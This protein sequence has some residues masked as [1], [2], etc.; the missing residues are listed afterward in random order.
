MKEVFCQRCNKEIKKGQKAARMHMYN[1]FPKVSD[2][3]YFHFNC[4]LEWRNEK[5][6]EAGMS[7]YKKG[8]KNIM[9]MIKP[10]AEKIAEN[11]IVT[12]SYMKKIKDLE[13][14]LTEARRILNEETKS[15]L[16]KK[17]TG[18]LLSR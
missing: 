10:M 1:E 14:R 15:N 4:F 13:K 11:I 5:I 3:R 12:N 8:M 2:E 16:R 7:A 9:P 17:R 18:K 6:M